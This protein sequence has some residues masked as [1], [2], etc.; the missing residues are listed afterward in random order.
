M[1]SDKYLNALRPFM[2][3]WDKYFQS[4]FEQDNVICGFTP[5]DFPLSPSFRF[6]SIGKFEDYPVNRWSNAMLH[7]LDEV[8]DD[9]FIL[10]LE[11]YW[12]TRPANTGAIK[13]LYDYMRQFR[14]VLKMD[15]VGDRL[16]AH[17]ADMNYGTVGYLDLIKSMP[18]SPYHMSLMAGLWNRDLLKKV[19]I[20]DETPW[21]VEISGTTRVSRYDNDIL[22]LG[23]RQWPM[24]HTLAFR[25]GDHQKLLLHELNP[26]DVEEMQSFGLF[27]WG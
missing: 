17:G 2:W 3:L 21:D 9:T 12:L 10:L 13:I 1:T 20:P 24:R 27:D 26:K 4:D 5:P 16:Y 11:D 19:L 18:G 22:V 14:Y 8:A 7:V 15:L 6:Y 23:T 25:G